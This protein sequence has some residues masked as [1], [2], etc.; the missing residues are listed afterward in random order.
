M[1]SSQVTLLITAGGFGSSA[2][3][4]LVRDAVLANTAD[5]IASASQTHSISKIVVLSDSDAPLDFPARVQWDM[6]A[7]RPFI[8]G[9]RLERA[10]RDYCEGTGVLVIGGGALVGGTVSDFEQITSAMASSPGAC[11]ANNLHSADLFG[12]MDCRAIAR[13][14]PVPRNDNEIPFRL[15]NELGMETIELT[16]SW[17]TKVDIDAPLDLALIKLSGAPGVYLSKFLESHPIVIPR[18]EQA[19]STLLFP[20]AEVFLAGRVDFD[21]V[22]ALS[23]RFQC[24]TKV[25]SELK[26]PRSSQSFS[27]LSPIVRH[28]GIPFFF[29]QLLPSACNLALIDVF[30]FFSDFPDIPSLG[31]RCAMDLND[32]SAISTPLLLEIQEAA[33]QSPIPILLGGHSTVSGTLILLSKY[34]LSKGKV[35]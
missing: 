22:R 23:R 14:L 21:A 11:I 5:L 7:S 10:I 26:A 17:R 30:S 25:F 20:G 6:D 12:L 2:E 35:A 31:E 9:A 8:Y 13:L 3:E 33:S 28:L 24:R 16:T 4:I 1:P 29:T 27:L 18:L 32:L 19:L 15:R 34:S